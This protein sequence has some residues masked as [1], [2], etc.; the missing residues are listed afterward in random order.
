MVLTRLLNSAPSLQRGVAF[1]IAL[2]A[3]LFAIFVAASLLQLLASQHANIDEKR[4]TLGRLLSIIALEKAVETPK[5]QVEE[6]NNAEF[7]PE[8]NEPAS[9]GGLQ[10]RLS[11]IAAAAG[12]T[13]LSAGNA[14]TLNDQ[15]VSYVG[16]RVSISGSLEQVHAFILNLETTMPVLFIRETNLRMAGAGSDFGQDREPEIS[17]D[18]LFY[19]VLRA[20]T[21]SAKAEASP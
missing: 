12:V 19:G 21:D 8:E 17:G 9:R 13:V 2:A 6:P 3:C 7:L 11:E 18:L 20:Q 4:S 10:T 5:G 16:L 15:G 14:P 1:G